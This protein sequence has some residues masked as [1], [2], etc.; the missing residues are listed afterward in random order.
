MDANLRTAI[1]AGGLVTLCC[2]GTILLTNTIRVSREVALDATGHNV[3][4]SGGQTI[5]LFEVVAG[6]HFS[7]TNLVL[8]DGAHTGASR[9]P[10]PGDPGWG[11]AIFNDGGTIALV[12]SVL[13]NNRAEGGQQ[14]T[15]AGGAIFSRNG[16]VFLLGTSLSNNAA[17]GGVGGHV[18]V[19]LPAPGG[20]A[21]GGAVYSETGSV[22]VINSILSNNQ[23]R[24]E[25]GGDSLGGARANG[26]ALFQSSGQLSISNT[27]FAANM[28]VGGDSRLG[29][30]GD[31]SP[32]GRAYGG[33]LAAVAGDV[34][35]DASR[36]T[37]NSARG[38][39]A[40]RYSGTG[41]AQGG[42]LWINGHL[43]AADTSFS[44]NQ[45]LSGHDSNRNTDGRGGAIH[46]GGSAVLVRCAI[47][48][49]AAIGAN[50]GTFGLPTV[51]F[52][53]GHG[54]GGGVYNAGQLATTNCSFFL[55][56]ALGGQAG[57]D[58][59]L[60]G[61]GFGGGIY[62]DAVGTV[63]AMNITVASNTVAPGRGFLYQ[64][65]AGG[66]SVASK[67]NG[68]FRLRNSIL[69]AASTNGN[70]WGVI[71]D[72]GYNLI[73]DA[74]VPLDSGTGF[75]STD[76]LLAPPGSNGGPTLTL[77]LLAGSP[78][79]DAGTA[80]GAPFADQRGFCRPAG[81]GVDMGAYEKGAVEPLRLNLVRSDESITLLFELP[82]GWGTRLQM[83]SPVP[84]NWV[85]VETFL[86][87][88]EPQSISRTFPFNEAKARLFRL[89]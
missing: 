69:A 19:E 36:F 88:P 67:T 5:R 79:I 85:D 37:S 28:A 8:A 46:N 23:C 78:A 60:P 33:A 84:N 42:A 57:F 34:S 40:W 65:T 2:N 59:G 86:S 30:A 61:S 4:I 75:S 31:Q 73:A 39:S 72:G 7:V 62:N 87:S 13:R 71:T 41:E 6:V 58:A 81:A 76:P 17:L 20:D 55:N 22:V 74:S 25:Y 15:A 52:P 16:S 53:G 32:P 27:T 10:P 63:D 24:V 14:A 11:G 80:E 64:G 77:A 89:H 44:Q 83:Y 66:A 29:F 9:F 18:P 56:S 82:A 49:N 26:G 70:G 45:A 47:H 12:G 50:A 54:L 68:T 35:I 51:N 3:I 48:S 43:V 38:G 21:F 1:E